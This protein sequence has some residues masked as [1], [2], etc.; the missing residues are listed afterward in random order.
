MVAAAG[1]SGNSVVVLVA[2]TLVLGLASVDGRSLPL[3]DVPR[4]SALFGPAAVVGAAREHEALSRP[5]SDTI[6]TMA[7]RA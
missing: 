5:V 3:V 4:W 7:S 2:G 1:G 6:A